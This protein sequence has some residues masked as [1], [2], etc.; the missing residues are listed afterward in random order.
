MNAGFTIAPQN[1][2]VQGY[3]LEEL[4]QD[5]RL[6]L[7]EGWWRKPC[8]AFTHTRQSACHGIT[9][10]RRSRLGLH[11]VPTEFRRFKVVGFLVFF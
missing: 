3:E 4:Y 8:P 1:K 5:G 9:M 11:A 10:P 6:S 7:G 2:K